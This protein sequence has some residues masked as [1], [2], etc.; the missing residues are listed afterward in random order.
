MKIFKQFIM[1]YRKGLTF[2]FILMTLSSFGQTYF[3]SLYGHDFR[4]TFSLS[5][6]ELGGA[7]AVGTILS[8][9]SLTWLGRLIDYTTTRYFTIVVGFVLLVACLLVSGAQNVFMLCAAFYLLRLGGQGLM[10]HTALTA[11]ARQ[12]PLNAGKA[13]GIIAL[14]LSLAQAI[15][16]M[17]VVN[18]NSLIGWR[19]S[20]VINALLLII[21]LGFALNSLPCEK[22]K[23]LRSFKVKA[24]EGVE[25]KS[26]WRDRN[27]TLALPVI[28]ASPFITTGFFFHQ[29]RL[30]QENN[31][32]LS[33]VA[34][35]FIA[36]A[37]TQA[38]SLVFF[39]PIIDRLTPRR[40]LPWYLVPLGAAMFSIWISSSEWVVPFYLIMIG[41]SSAIASTLST[42]LWVQLFGPK[43][44]ARVRSA[45]EA[46]TV[47][48]SGISPM[49]M[50]ML[51]DNNVTL[52]M[53][54]LG[55]LIYIILAS[56]LATK[57]RINN[58]E[59]LHTCSLR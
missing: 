23:P 52:K 28:L 50:G 31:W 53:Q 38:I 54:S 21:G 5:D 49:I 51:I 20:W 57:V 18:I 36:Y 15:F 14:G 13:L 26:I 34:I 40:I 30:S 17:I 9:I 24:S 55:C 58:N 3:I 19:L 1:N 32:Q 37:I 25:E 47:L 35:W 12:F 6:G 27:L 8:A 39:G 44:L 2:G 10:V 29:I 11:T 33:W 4:N 43:Q 59:D 45:V 22:E 16:P 48:A 56:I 7:Y 46:G 41:V 42:A